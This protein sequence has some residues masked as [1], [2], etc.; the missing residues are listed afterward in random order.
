[1]TPIH[2]HGYAFNS[3]FPFLDDLSLEEMQKY[4]YL[5]KRRGYVYSVFGG[6]IEGIPALEQYRIFLM[7]RDPRDVLT[8]MYYSSAYSHPVPEATGDKREAFLARRRHTREISIDQFALE[9]AE[10]KRAIYQHY[11]DLLVKKTSA[12]IY[13]VT[14]K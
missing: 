4:A 12:F 14:K 1:M 11:T 5:F 7:V 13:L 6:A 3:A 9:N 10:H 2:L 8:S